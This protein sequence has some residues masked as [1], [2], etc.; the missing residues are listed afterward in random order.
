MTYEEMLLEILNRF[1]GDDIST[2]TLKTMEAACSEEVWDHLPPKIRG[3]WKLHLG[4][5]ADNP[6]QIELRPERVGRATPEELEAALKAPFQSFSDENIEGGMS[7]FS[8]GMAGDMNSSAAA[9]TK[10]VVDEM[11]PAPERTDVQTEAP[12]PYITAPASTETPSSG[13]TGA[14]DIAKLAEELGISLPPNSSLLQPFLEA[15]AVASE[16]KQRVEALEAKIEEI[17]GR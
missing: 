1:R 11:P 7:G 9:A 12:A 2:G 13:T 16:Y 3:S 5:D 14:S 10:P 15:L 4:V 17:L 6:N 8:V